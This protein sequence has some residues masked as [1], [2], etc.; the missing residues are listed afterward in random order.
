MKAFKALIDAVGGIEYNV[1]RNMNYDDP[2]Q[3]LHIHYSKGVQRLSGQQALEVL[4][5]RRYADADIGRIRT[6]QDFL[7]TAA[8]Q[9]LAAKG[10]IKVL[11]IANIFIN[12][13]K[14]DMTLQNIIWLASELYKLDSENITFTTMP[15][16]YNA[17]VNGDSYVTI[18]VDDWLKVIN[19]KL[20]PFLEPI[21]LDE[22][23]IYT[24]NSSG[25][26]YLTSGELA[27]SQSWG[28]GGSSA[29]TSPT[30]TPTPTPAST[31]NSAPT[32]SAPPQDPDAASPPA[33]GGETAEPGTQEPTGPEAS[34]GAEEGDGQAIDG[35][36]RMEG[37]SVGD[38]T[39]LPEDPE[40]P[41]GDEP[42][43]SE[44]APPADPPV[45]PDAAATP[46]WL[47]R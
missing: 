27:G 5:F 46:D 40:V 23:S 21:R 28:Q 25:A 37:D 14:T 16:D 19:D 29:R 8:G 3:N 17:S 47:P 2:A 33:D 43:Q 34:P 18:Y 6:Q 39:I 20:N 1:P 4:R 30:P 10:S 44:Q 35:S 38:G 12:Y 31:P 22:L 24:R 41:S 26:L 42:E 13:V 45:D 11:D 32:P 7:M 15:G 36:G 9:L